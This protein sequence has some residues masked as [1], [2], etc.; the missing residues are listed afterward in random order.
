MLTV[1][2]GYGH[3]RNRIGE[4]VLSLTVRV[5]CDLSGARGASGKLFRGGFEDME[6]EGCGDGLLGRVFLAR[7]VVRGRLNA[8]AGCDAQGR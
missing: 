4:T 6:R 5:K 1:R 2:V 3:T 8:F 7:K